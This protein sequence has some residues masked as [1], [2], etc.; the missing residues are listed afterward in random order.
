[1]LAEVDGVGF[2]DGGDA[3]KLSTL[4]RFETEATRGLEADVRWPRPVTELGVGGSLVV[5]G[6]TLTEIL[7][8]FEVMRMLGVGLG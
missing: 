6:F 2:R 5:D 8:T 3:D 4:R 1:V 7:V